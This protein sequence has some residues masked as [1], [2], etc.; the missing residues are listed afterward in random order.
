[1]L[2]KEMDYKI[3]F[4]DKN[5]N[6]VGFDYTSSC[7]E[8]FGWFVAAEVGGVKLDDSAISDYWFDVNHEPIDTTP[9]DGYDEGGTVA[10]RMTNANGGALYLHLY[11]HHNGCYS[12]GWESSWGESGAL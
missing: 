7:C 2:I 3:N 9:E 6:F 10:F 5:D 4:I 1:M 8:D 12:H 11:N